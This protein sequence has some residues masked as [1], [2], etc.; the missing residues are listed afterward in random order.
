MNN[1]A[2]LLQRYIP[3]KKE[4][5]ES[6]FERYFKKKQEAILDFT[7]TASSAAILA[8][9]PM[10]EIDPLLFSAIQMTNPRFDATN[11]ENYT[12]EELMG[13]VNSAK[14][15]Y[16]ELLVADKLNAGERVGDIILPEGYR[17]ELAESLTQPGWD[18][19]I[20][21][22]NDEIVDY[23]QLKATQSAQYIKEALVRYPDIQILATHEATHAAMDGFVLNSGISEETLRQD[24]LNAFS[25]S[26]S[27]VLDAFLD[28]F[29]PLLPLSLMLSWEGYQLVIG[30]NSLDQFK[31][32]LARRTQRVVAAGASSAAVYAL[33]GGV[34]GAV[35]TTFLGGYLFDRY[36][37]QLKIV[38]NLEGYTHF[39]AMRQ[40]IAVQSNIA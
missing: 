31:L 11:F 39:I 29:S 9:A 36:L 37:N 16:F 2:N 25:E 3:L 24:I 27:G 12:N 6:C 22:E 10:K 14:G 13:I 21:G 30:K 4:T 18:L 7:L 28:Y 5:F 38:Q 20:V 19:K 17:A 35:S 40:K 32:N 15:K 34:I 1:F 26:N 8:G 23:L 33:G